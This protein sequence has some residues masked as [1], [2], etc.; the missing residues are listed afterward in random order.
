MEAAISLT[1][2]LVC[3]DETLVEYGTDLLYLRD[4]FCG[5]VVPSVDFVYDTDALVFLT[6]DLSTT[7]RGPHRSVAVREFSSNT[8]TF[9]SVSF[10]EVPVLVRRV[11]VYWRRAFDEPDLFARITREHVFQRLTESNKP[12]QAF[13]TGLYITP[14][15]QTSDALQFFLLRCSSNFSGPTE[16]FGPT[17]WYIVDKANAMV[18]EWF[19]KGA[20]LN[21]VLAQVYHNRME[22]AKMKKATIK[23][24]SDKTKDMPMNGVIA[25]CTFYDAQDVDVSLLTR[26]RFKLK[27]CVPEPTTLARS[28]DVTLHPNSMFVIPLSTN[29]LYTHEIVPSA[30]PVSKLPTRMGYVIRSSDTCATHLDGRTY[31]KAKD[32][33]PVPLSLPTPDEVR[34]L[35]EQYRR[36]NTT[37]DKVDYGP[38]SFSLN[39][40]DFMRPAAGHQGLV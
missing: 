21:H 20:E 17:D 5:H 19:T 18:R 14:V 29:R 6:G 39:Q 37:A 24:H 16:N 1:H 2:F 15:M 27:P 38:V 25:F 32:G 28:F 40:G 9:P 11:G 31:I 26:L 8:D 3:S 36:E 33:S 13:R 22:G 7:V 4:N 34:Q 30:A 10:K 35:K 12:G 23:A